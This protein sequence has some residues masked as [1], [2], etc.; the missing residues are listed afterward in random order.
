MDQHDSILRHTGSLVGPDGDRWIHSRRAQ[1]G[2][3][4]RRQRDQHKNDWHNRE[5][6]WIQGPNAV[7]QLLNE[8]AHGER[9]GQSEQYADNGQPTAV[10][11][12]QGG[13]LPS[14]RA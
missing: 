13:D 14:R 10:T 8:A 3:Q 7:Q 6:E 11:Q 1:C 4:T 12:D 5:R 2:D 9:N